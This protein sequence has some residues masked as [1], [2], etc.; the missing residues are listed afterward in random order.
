MKPEF[1]DIA[2]YFKK[3]AEDFLENP[4]SDFYN[5]REYEKKIFDD[6]TTLNTSIRDQSDSARALRSMG[7]LPDRIIDKQ[8][9]INFYRNRL[10]EYLTYHKGMES[11]RARDA[12]SSHGE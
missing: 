4:S 3:E 11:T 5:F 12:A 10:Y 6:K 9:V 1:G 8:E 2:T 7:I